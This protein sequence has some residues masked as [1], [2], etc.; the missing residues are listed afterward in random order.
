[1]KWKMLTSLIVLTLLSLALTGPATALT[2][3]LAFC[4]NKSNGNLRLAT[5]ASDCRNSDIFVSFELG[6]A[7]PAGPAGPSGPEGPAGPPGPAGPSGDAGPA[8]STG[9]VFLNR[10]S[11]NVALAAFPG[12]TTATLLLPPGDYMLFAKFRY[13]GNAAAGAPAETA[14]CVFQGVG[15]GGLDS[16]Q[17][18]VPPGGEISGQIDAFMMDV[19]HKNAGDDPDVHIQ[20]FGPADLSVINTM[21]VAVTGTINV[22]P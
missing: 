19:V 6:G 8:G 22:Q 21:F 18:N 17:N 2:S 20:C 13:R 5:S 1:M 12:V 4:E 16:S 3:T 15:I 9:P 7:G 10:N 14:S 11:Q